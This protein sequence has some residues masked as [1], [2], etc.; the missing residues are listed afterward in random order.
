M[1]QQERT[2]QFLKGN[3]VLQKRRGSVT[4]GNYDYASS[5]GKMI[6]PTD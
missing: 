2:M 4:A 3:Q 6:I 5:H 1:I